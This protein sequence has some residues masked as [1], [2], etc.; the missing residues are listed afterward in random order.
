[1][2]QTKRTDTRRLAVVGVLLAATIIGHEPPNDVFV[3][4]RWS[5]SK[6]CHNNV[7]GYIVVWNVSHIYIYIYR[8]REREMCECD[9]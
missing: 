1:M 4:R 5:N 7:E 6:A 8:E 3:L 2:S 9:E